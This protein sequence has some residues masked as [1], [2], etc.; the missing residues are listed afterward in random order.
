MSRGVGVDSAP[1][2]IGKTTVCFTRSL[3]STGNNLGL[4]RPGLV[5]R[6]DARAKDAKRR[7]QTD[8]Q[9]LLHLSPRLLQ[10][11]GNWGWPPTKASSV[12]SQY[13][14]GPVAA[15]SVLGAGGSNPGRCRHIPDD[16]DGQ[17]EGPGLQSPPAAA[18]L[19]D[20]LILAGWSCGGVVSVPT[21]LLVDGRGA[22]RHTGAARRWAEAGTGGLKA[23]GSDER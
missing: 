9:L 23:G 6:E 4:F 11:E 7:G 22:L 15:T 18:S 19:I 1:E 2:R 10:R 20:A 13:Q 12:P 3:T 5:A 17:R 16:Y 8:R 14:G 21:V